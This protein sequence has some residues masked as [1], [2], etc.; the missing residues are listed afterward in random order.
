MFVKYLILDGS[1]YKTITSNTL[2]TVCT[3]A[4]TDTVMETAFRNNGMNDLTSVNN[5]IISQVS[6]SDFKI[7]MYKSPR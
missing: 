1:N 2:S 4:D 3:V 7:V 5:D 6:S